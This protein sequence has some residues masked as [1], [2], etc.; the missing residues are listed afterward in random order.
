MYRKLRRHLVPDA[1]RCDIYFVRLFEA[2]EKAG[3]DGLA[4]SESMQTVLRQYSRAT[5]DIN[6]RP[7]AFEE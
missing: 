1:S 3:G 5:N 2:V 6:S 7:C 4:L